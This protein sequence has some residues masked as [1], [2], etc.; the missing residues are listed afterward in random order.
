MIRDIVFL[1]MTD[2][3]LAVVWEEFLKTSLVG[4]AH[5]GNGSTVF[6]YDEG[7]H[8]WDAELCW[9][10][11]ALVNIDLDENAFAFE[12]LS[13]LLENGADVDTGAAPGGEEINDD[14]EVTS[15]GSDF[16]IVG[17]VFDFKNHLL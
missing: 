1:T 15:L 10:F 6:H 4:A 14:G 13:E 2:I 9:K 3:S 8:G 5:V 7:R 17:C 16:G 12:L 11:L